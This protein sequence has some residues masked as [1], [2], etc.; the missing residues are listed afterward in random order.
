MGVSLLETPFFDVVW[1]SA[2]ATCWRFSFPEDV[3]DTS[4]KSKK[5]GV[6][7]HRDKIAPLRNR[8]EILSGPRPHS[9]ACV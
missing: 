9:L 7:L 5:V 2:P 1:K 6:M 8:V 3:A 4:Q